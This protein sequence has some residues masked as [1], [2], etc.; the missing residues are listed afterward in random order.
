MNAEE[1]TKTNSYLSFNMNEE[2]YAVNVSSVLSILELPRITK[3]P[4]APDYIKGMINLRGEVL[5]V[6]DFH[7]K[8]SMAATEITSNTC[9][10]VIEINVND[11]TLKCGI[12]VDSVNE[13]YEI[14][15]DKILPPPSMG[16]SF[17]SDFIEGIYRN[18]ESLIM[19]VNIENVFKYQDLSTIKDS[20]ESIPE[21]VKPLTE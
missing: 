14:E 7:V 18:G 17:R 3:I 12:M 13:V 20:V 6:V 4:Q 1:V 2:V 16:N 15:A 10:L 11:E 19:L 9:I 5:S 21:D 8:L